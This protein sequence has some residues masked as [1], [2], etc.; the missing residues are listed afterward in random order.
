M[1]AVLRRGRAPPASHDEVM[2]VGPCA[3]GR[4]TARSLGGGRPIDLSR[5]EF[6]LLALLMAHAGQVVTRDG[7]STVSGGPRP[8]RHP[9]AG[10]H[11]KRLR[12]K[13]EDPADP[14]HLVT[15]R[16]VG[17]PFRG[18]SDRGSRAPLLSRIF[19]DAEATT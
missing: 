14:R 4:R 5:K 8:L 15:V 6:D 17:I 2:S 19:M 10:H 16:G 11:V 13:I 7:A 12:R 1:R 9:H 18:L 3:P